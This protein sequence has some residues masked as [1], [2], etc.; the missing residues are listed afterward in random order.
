M[1]RHCI[2]GI[3]SPRVVNNDLSVARTLDI[4]NSV[5]PVG[6]VSNLFRSELMQDLQGVYVSRVITLG[7]VSPSLSKRLE[8]LDTASKGSTSPRVVSNDLSVVRALRGFQ[9]SVD[10]VDTFQIRGQQN[11][12]GVCVLVCGDKQRAKIEL[13]YFCIVQV[14]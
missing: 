1:I 7:S 5:D 14:Q 10:P 9:S 6:T 11:L 3:Y 8:Q 2:Q 4:K 13:S 12:Y